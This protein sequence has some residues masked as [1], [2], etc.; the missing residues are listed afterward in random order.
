[1]NTLQSSI[2]NPQPIANKSAI[3]FDMSTEAG[4]PAGNGDGPRYRK[5]DC[6]RTRD[7]G[8][9][10]RMSSQQAVGLS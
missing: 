8:P 3:G 7:A 1:M 2:C 4:P 9:G 10:T 5:A 6:V